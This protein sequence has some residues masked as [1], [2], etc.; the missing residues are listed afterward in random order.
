M[1]YR[2]PDQQA[3]IQ[4]LNCIFFIIILY[5]FCLFLTSK[6]WVRSKHIERWCLLSLS[7]F[8]G[9][10]SYT[11]RIYCGDRYYNYIVISPTNVT[12]YY[13]YDDYHYHCY[14]FIGVSLV[15]G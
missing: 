3:G 7:I 14:T 12:Y 5:F 8:L 1:L 10:Y 4:I 15:L 6:V 11:I 2:L 9:L 13:Y